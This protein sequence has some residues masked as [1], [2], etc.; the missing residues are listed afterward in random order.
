MESV[1]GYRFCLTS[2]SA[3][4]VTQLYRDCL[5]LVNHVAPGYSPKA[6]ALRTMVQSEFRKNMELTDPIAIENA[7]AGAVRALANYMVFQ[8][9]AQDAHVSKAM[10]SFHTSSV[11]EAKKEQV[12]L[13]QAEE[14]SDAEK[15]ERR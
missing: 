12:R 14:K 6:I 8:S 4:D 9:G 7:K 15:D 10:S 2:P 3:S 11:E 5:R 1:V 13:Q